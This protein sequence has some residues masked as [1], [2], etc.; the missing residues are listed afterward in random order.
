MAVI[1]NLVHET[2]TSTGTGSLTLSNV[3]GK[4]SFNTAFG[5]GGTDVFYYFLSN[6]AA[7]EWEVGTGHLSAATT[8]VRDT[9]IGG[10]NGGSAVNFGAGT[11]DAT[12]DIV[13][14]RQ[15]NN[16]GSN[17]AF[18]LADAGADAIFGWDDSV[19]QYENLTG[20]EAF[21]VVQA[22]AD[23]VYQPL[24][25]DLTSWAGV[26]RASG[27]D[28]FVA[29]PSSANLDSL[30]TGNTGSGALCFATSPGFTTAANPV[31]NDGA[32]LG[33]TALGWSDLFL[34]DGGVVN[35]GNGGVTVTH[36]AASDSLAFVLDSGAALGSTAFTVSLDGTT[37]FSLNALNS[38]GTKTAHKFD[39]GANTNPRFLIRGTGNDSTLGPAIELWHESGSPAANDYPGQII[40]M[41]ESSTSV[42]REYGALSGKIITAT[43]T[44][45]DFA[46][47]FWCMEAGTEAV[48]ARID[49][50]GLKFMGDTAA[51][52][53]LDDYEKGTWEPTYFTTGTQFTSVTYDSIR[54]GAYTKIGNVCYYSL[55]LQT[56]AI[57]VGSAS[58]VVSIDLPF[59]SSLTQDMP[60]GIVSG[61]VAAFAGDMPIGSVQSTGVAS[62]RLYYRT[63]SNGATTGLAPSDMGTGANANTLYAF[64]YYFTSD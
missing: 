9:V 41:G 42:L 2:T 39:L 61:H 3:F 18:S 37:M 16:L 35:W 36:T 59:S 31:S 15:I 50:D 1:D 24:D 57:T 29:T 51:A 34:A 45:E 7:A 13:A 32:A 5:T 62:V 43:N 48:K 60:G 22:S 56:D 54:N 26:T 23:A 19:A 17:L 20:A 12:C 38:E 30:V 21:A 27:F 58:G 44:A 52:N 28:T 10:S 6:R 47:E 14:T 8:L 33:T 49:G 63:A 53:A 64:G 40:F 4:Q 25:S 46:F 11:K 55:I